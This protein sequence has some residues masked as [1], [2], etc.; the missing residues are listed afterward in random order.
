MPPVHSGSRAD[1]L[2]PAPPHAVIELGRLSRSGMQEA[3]PDP[4]PGYS[5]VTGKPASSESGIFL[6]SGT[7]RSGCWERPAGDPQPRRGVGVGIRTRGW[8]GR[9]RGSPSLKSAELSSQC[10]VSVT[11]SERLGTKKTAESAEE[12]C[13]GVKFADRCRSS[14]PP[15]GAMATEGVGQEGKFV[16]C[17]FQVSLPLLPAPGRVFVKERSF[18]AKIETSFLQSQPLSETKSWSRGR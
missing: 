8:A 7:F 16:L 5:R 6:F 3:L 9:G 1:V 18:F 2:V 14:K 15:R 4:P 13:F 12:V 11:L 17:F 10:F